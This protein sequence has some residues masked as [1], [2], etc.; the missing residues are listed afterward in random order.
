MKLKPIE[1][2]PEN[3]SIVVFNKADSMYVRRWCSQVDKIILIPTN[4]NY[5]PIE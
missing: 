2:M 5:K 4:S 1:D 3:G